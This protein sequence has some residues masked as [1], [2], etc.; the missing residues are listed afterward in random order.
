MLRQV[1]FL[2]TFT[3][4]Q[5]AARAALL[6][7]TPPESILWQELGHDQPLLEIADEPEP[8]QSARSTIK[9]PKTFVE[10]ATRVACHRDPHRWTLLYRVLWRLTHGEHELMAV[11]VDPDVHQI[12]QMDRAIRRDVHKMRA[13]VRFRA[14]EH[15]GETWYGAW[16]EPAHHVVE[17][18]APFFVDRFTQMRWSIL[19]PDRCMHW[20]G[21]QIGF[22]KGVLKS[23]APGD[24]V[25]ELLWRKYYASIFNPARV[26]V[27]AMMAEMPKRYWKNLPEARV[28]PEL[29]RKA[30]SRVD[31]MMAKSRAEASEKRTKGN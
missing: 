4:W 21:S 26:K 12:A 3:G 25:I 14:V 28:I 17:L 15:G 16:F 20:D 11:V 8:V 18:N 13:F 7:E 19:T 10:I 31:S 30:P 6:A 23:E 22:T 29:L 9:V 1:T 24:D 5:R 27:H 2:P